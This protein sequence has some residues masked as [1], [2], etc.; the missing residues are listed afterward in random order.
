MLVTD[1]TKY[2]KTI[3]A[4]LTDEEIQ[5]LNMLMN[6]HNC[7]NL[8]EFLKLLITGQID[9]PADKLADM[10]TDLKYLKEKFKILEV[11]GSN[12]VP[13]I[14]RDLILLS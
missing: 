7:N 2:G 9:I 1:Q 4:R 8:S 12:P 3:A 10:E 5:S 6:K 14:Y 11:A 13:G